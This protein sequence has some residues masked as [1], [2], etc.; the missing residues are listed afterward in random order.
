MAFSD[1]QIRGLLINN[2][3]GQGY[4]WYSWYFVDC[5][6]SSEIWSYIFSSQSYGKIQEQKLAS[7]WAKWLLPAAQLEVDMGS[8]EDRMV[9]RII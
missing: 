1:V 2:D 4:I 3:N 7:S 8:A 9:G 5:M 6:D